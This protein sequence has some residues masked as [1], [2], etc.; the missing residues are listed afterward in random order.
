MEMMA[1]LAKNAVIAITAIFLLDAIA[2]LAM[3]PPQAQC[4][5]GGSDD[6]HRDFSG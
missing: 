4:L 2:I 3:I 5:N 1:G 6:H